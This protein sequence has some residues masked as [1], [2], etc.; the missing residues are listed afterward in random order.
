MF[1]FPVFIPSL[2]QTDELKTLTSR[3]KEVVDGPPQL[4]LSALC[5]SS[6]ELRASG[7]TGTR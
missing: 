5:V 7:T 3:V 4:H 2:K 1:I 6:L